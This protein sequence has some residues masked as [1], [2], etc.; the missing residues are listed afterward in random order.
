MSRFSRRLLAPAAAMLLAAGAMGAAHAA[1]L[2]PQARSDLRPDP[3]VRFGILANGMRYA[4]MRNAT[5]GG[6]TSL[7][8]RIGSGSLEE[9][10]DEQGL[11][12][13]LEHM[14][15]KGSVHV[16][17]GDMIQILQRKG[18]AFGPDTNAETGWTQTVYMLDLPHGDADTI[19]TGLMLM[20]ETAGNLLIDDKALASERGV[21]LSEE[22]LR[23]TPRYRAQKAQIGLF[24]QGQ[25]A[26]DRFPIG[27][28]D[29]IEHAPASLVKAFYRANYRPDRA[30]LIAVGDFDP[31]RMEA[32]IR[33]RFSDWAPVGPPTAE[34]DLGQPKARGLT[35]RVVQVPGSSTEILLAWTRPFDDSADTAARERRETVENI[36]LAVLNRRLSRLAQG[37]NPPF[38]NAGAEFQ[39]LFHSEKLA[40]IQAAS[41]PEAWRPALD[42]VEQQV[43]RLAVQGVTQAEVDREV[44][45]LRTRLVAAV[46]GAPTRPTPELAS[47]LVRSVDE[48]EVFTAPSEDLSVFDAAVKDLTA[49]RVD[50]AVRAVFAGQGPLVDLATPVAVAGGDAALA[51]EY[52]RSAAIPLSAPTALAAAPWPYASFGAPGRVVERHAVADLGL[53]TA[54][55]ANGVGLT[56]KSTHLRDDQVLVAVNFGSGRLGMPRTRPADTW[57]SAAFIAGGFGKMT[58]E[59]SQQALADKSYGVSLAIGDDAFVMGGATQ[60]TDLA[61][62]LQVMTAYLADPGFR[63]EAFERVRTA[64]LNQLPQLAATP[65]G[66]FARDVGSLFSS[67]DPRWAFPGRSE[68]IAARPADLKGL[69]GAALAD[70]PVEV[71]IVGDIDPERAIALTAATFGALP[72]RATAAKFDRARDTIRFPAPTALP[73]ERI[74]TGRADQAVAVIGWPMND[75]YA[76]MAASRAAMLAGEVLENALIDRLRVAEGATYSPETRVELSQ[77]FP[78]YGYAFSL[79]EMPPEKIPGFFAAVASIT[80]DMGAHGVSAD[81]LARAK[82]PRVAGLKKAQLTNEYWLADLAGSLRDP[83]RLDLIRS[84]FP[85]YAKVT[86]QD[87][88]QAARDWFVPD[89]AWKL[90][91]HA[92][93]KVAGALAETPVASRGPGTH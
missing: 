58:L 56:V 18:L 46:A 84:T 17:A 4:V 67:D 36:G 13:V 48:D 79:V 3:A 1:P 88:R 19:D 28:V 29:V 14:A 7:R 22:R 68:L 77:V 10:A 15:F 12:H 63:P 55:F 57:T 32:K 75:F 89:R 26:A 33:A 5:P 20:R 8:L 50:G 92:D 76:D 37:E 90:V 43:R 73:L 69:L 42:A 80:A 23:D 11:A 16:P 24:L 54:R 39:N 27:R 62:Q 78:G 66:V 61:T 40:V 51:A 53:V 91:I 52:A 21:V 2:W 34:P 47:E 74:D 35:A 85:D 9:S 49:A 65:N 44:V 93:P 41:T 81:E 30:T 70:G 25:L 6:Q 82:N 83:R 31:A 86:V 72:P 87:I 45:E 59:D 64:F 38:L 60:P 71:T